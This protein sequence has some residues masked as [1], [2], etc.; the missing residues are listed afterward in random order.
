MFFLADLADDTDLFLGNPCNLWEPFLV[1]VRIICRKSWI[2]LCL[3]S[4]ITDQNPCVLVFS[5]H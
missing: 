4:V 5:N 3:K 1:R 2:L